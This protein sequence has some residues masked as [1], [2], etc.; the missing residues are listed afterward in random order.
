[1]GTFS[2]TR[3]TGTVDDKKYQLPAG[4][5]LNFHKYQRVFRNNI[6][7]SYPIYMPENIQ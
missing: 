2:T 7:G 1:M 3:T 4:D 5:L 6:Y